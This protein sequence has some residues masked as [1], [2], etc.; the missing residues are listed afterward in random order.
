MAGPQ[1]PEGSSDPSK[2]EVPVGYGSHPA[3]LAGQRQLNK[4]TQ[5][6]HDAKKQ[7]VTS[8]GEGESTGGRLPQRLLS[9]S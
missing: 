6:S 1:A 7:A 4:V 9:D 5:G 2:A 8:A 3:Q